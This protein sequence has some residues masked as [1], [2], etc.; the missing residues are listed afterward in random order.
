MSDYQ[1]HGID[2]YYA[3]RP[4]TTP[5]DMVAALGG[6]ARGG[7]E[8]ERYSCNDWSCAEPGRPFPSRQRDSPV[9]PRC[10]P[11]AGLARGEEKQ[12]PNG[13]SRWTT[14]EYSGKNTNRTGYASRPTTAPE[15]M[16]AA[17]GGCAR[18]DHEYERYSCND[19]SCAEL[20]RPFPSRQRDGP[21]RQRCVPT[22]ALAEGEVKQEPSGKSRWTTGE[23]SAKKHQ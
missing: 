10:V 17:L 21:V 18:G 15:D 23:Y 19:W 4:T 12:G 5:E 9:Q 11:T 22:A 14:G 6:C 8:H 13:K 3:S 7:H 1:T 20:G 2:A 16:V